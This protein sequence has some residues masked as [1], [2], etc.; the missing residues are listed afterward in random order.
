MVLKA[1]GYTNPEIAEKLNVSTGTVS[2]RL[3][4]LHEEAKKTSPFFVFIKTLIEAGPD[5]MSRFSPVQ[6][7]PEEMLRMLKKEKEE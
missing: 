7:L 3:K 5:Y 4:K 6:H 1:T 2:Y